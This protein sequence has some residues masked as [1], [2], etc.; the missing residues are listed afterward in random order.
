M[1]TGRQARGFTYVGALLLTVIVALGL[2]TLGE[3]WSRLMQRE[4]EK[5]LVWRGKQY[6]DAIASYYERSPGA[7]KQY[8]K[9]LEELLDDRRFVT[10]QRHLRRLYLDPITLAPWD[11]ILSIDGGIMGVRS[12]SNRSVLG[13]HSIANDYSQ[14]TFVY[15]R[16]VRN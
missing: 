9:K 11:P 15:H 4:R 8:P 1:R 12:S 3:Q 16:A 7:V 13:L 6:R 14:I 10:T 5:E 2:A